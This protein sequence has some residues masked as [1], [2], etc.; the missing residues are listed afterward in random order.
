ML[1]PDTSERMRA[2]TSA[3]QREHLLRLGCDEVDIS[4]IIPNY[5]HHRLP[6]QLLSCEVVPPGLSPQEAVAVAKRK[7]QKSVE[8]TCQHPGCHLQV[9]CFKFILTKGQN[10]QYSIECG[11]HGVVQG[12]TYWRHRPSTFKCAVW[13]SW[14]GNNIQGTCHVCNDQIYCTLHVLDMWELCH[15]VARANGGPYS[16]HNIV[17]GSRRCNLVQRTLT[18][19]EYQRHIGS[20]SPADHVCHVSSGEFAARFPNATQ[21][22][23]EQFCKSDESN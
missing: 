12:N 11:N 1:L 6:H 19:A 15:D 18:I 16:L 8:I 5:V 2:T 7:F 14:I 10:K 3:R 20:A 9:T 17:P 21:E 4:N 22:L 23:L 13:Q